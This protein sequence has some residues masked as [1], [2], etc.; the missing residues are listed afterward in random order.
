MESGE[1]KS[2]VFLEKHA[3]GEVSVIV[4]TDHLLSRNNSSLL[5]NMDSGFQDDD[6]FILYESPAISSQSRR[7]KALNSSRLI[8][9]THG[10]VRADCVHR[11]S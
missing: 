3:F 1:H 8:R 2:S 4:R 7:I 11:T 9:C 10:L 5:H 6:G